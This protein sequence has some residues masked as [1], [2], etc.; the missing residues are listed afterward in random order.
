MSSM[1]VIKD[2][3]AQKRIAVVGVSHDPKDLSRALLRTFRERGY[4]AVAVNPKL[5]SVDDAPCFPRLTDIAPPVDAVLVMT[6]PAVT[7]QVVQE[8]AA[9]HIPRVWM[10]RGGGKGAVSPQAVEFCLDHGIAVVPGECP[11]M[12]LQGESWFHR[13]HGFIRKISGAYPA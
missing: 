9:L 12:F 5:S 6:A 3:L 10:Y 8:C 4:D 7:D 11:Y 1:A 13:L 2:F